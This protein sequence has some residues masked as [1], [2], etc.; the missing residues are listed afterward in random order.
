MNNNY[1]V[2]IK[3]IIDFGCP[4][5]ETAKSW[6]AMVVTELKKEYAAKEVWFQIIGQ[7]AAVDDNIQ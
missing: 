4:T 6:V 1:R 2:E 5:D 7:E 3:L